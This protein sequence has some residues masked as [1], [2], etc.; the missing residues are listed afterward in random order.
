MIRLTRRRALVVLG[1]LIVLALVL[2]GRWLNA[3]KLGG[4]EPAEPFRI[5]GNFY[6]VGANDVSAFL[7]TGPEGHIVLDGGYPTTAP[8]IMA[9]MPRR[10]PAGGF[11]LITVP[12]GGFVA[13][14]LPI[15][16]T[17]LWVPLMSESSTLIKLAFA[18]AGKLARRALRASGRPS[19]YRKLCLPA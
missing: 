17:F 7:I 2:V 10:P 9:S 8:M 16:L 6:Y 3:T 11:P 1:L 13:D 18:R 5:A 19:T 4:Q 15:G 12:G 14:L